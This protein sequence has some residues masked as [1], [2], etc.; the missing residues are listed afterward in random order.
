MKGGRDILNLIV[1]LTTICILAALALA[2]VYEITKD[3]ITEQQ[4]LARLQAV[5]AVL[6]AHDNEPDQDIVRLSLG[7]GEDRGKALLVYRGLAK[8]QITGV[9]FE[10]SATGY[11]GEIALMI[12][13]NLDGTIQGV[14]ITRMSETPGLG[15][16]I[17]EPVF[18]GQFQGKSLQKTH[19]EL[20]KYGGELDQISGA[21]ISPRAVIQAIRTGLEL[22]EKHKKE[23]LVLSEGHK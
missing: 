12:G 2:K 18:T 16:K 3:P 13:L 10:M 4:R 23:I 19:L 11:G 17:T 7:Q 15:A 14:E 1:V 6:P 9:A 22:Y 21:T 20:K 8:G 5:N